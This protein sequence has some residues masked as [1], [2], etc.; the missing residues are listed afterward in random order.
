MPE[1]ILFCVSDCW[2]QFRIVRATDAYSAVHKVHT[3][4]TYKQ[5]QPEMLT[6][7]TV[8][9]VMCCE[10]NGLN[11]E[12]LDRCTNDVDRVLLMDTFID[13]LHYQII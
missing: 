10:Y 4:K 1:N 12:Y 8:I 3:R 11:K 2:T 13:T 9:H 5:I 7:Q 6:E